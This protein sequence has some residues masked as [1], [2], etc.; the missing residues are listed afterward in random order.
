MNSR[1]YQMLEAMI[2]EADSLLLIEMGNR[3]VNARRD[4]LAAR[5]D[6]ADWCR[7]YEQS[8]GYARSFLNQYFAEVRGQLNMALWNYRGAVQSFHRLDRGYE[9]RS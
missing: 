7:D 3:H 6:A 4:L 8:R 2:D 9:S 5:Q 1:N